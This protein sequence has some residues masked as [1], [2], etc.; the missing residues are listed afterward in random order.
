[1][2]T[3]P[4][5]ET[6]FFFCLRDTQKRTQGLMLACFWWT[7]MVGGFIFRWSTIDFVFFLY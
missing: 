4:A 3:S 7:R 6:R 2:A 5:S 1:M